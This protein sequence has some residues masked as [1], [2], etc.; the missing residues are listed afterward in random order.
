MSDD[1][2]PKTDT[3]IEPQKPETHTEHHEEKPPEPQHDESHDRNSCPHCSEIKGIVGDVLSTLQAA[4][5]HPEPDVT[6]AKKPWFAR[7]G[8]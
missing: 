5:P 3:V 6:P 2:T 8:K 7:G 1:E 4:A